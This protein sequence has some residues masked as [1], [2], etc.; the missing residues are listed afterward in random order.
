MQ[1]TRKRWRS[2]PRHPTRTCRQGPRGPPCRRGG[3]R[4]CGAGWSGFHPFPCVGPSRCWPWPLT[5]PTG[6]RQS[7]LLTCKPSWAGP[8]GSPLPRWPLWPGCS[9]GWAGAAW[10]RRPLGRRG[11]SHAPTS[12]RAAR[13]RSPPGS[14]PEREGA[15]R[16]RGPSRSSSSRPCPP[17]TARSD[18]LCVACVYRCMCSASASPFVGLARRAPVE[19]VAGLAIRLPV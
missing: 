3:P 13:P 2:R 6:S 8:W 17:A 10:R 18:G 11:G 9:G 14:G 15:P 7:R 19:P 16:M 4:R 1:P 12:S 5:T